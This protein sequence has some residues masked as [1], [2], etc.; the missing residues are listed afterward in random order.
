[1]DF[2]DKVCIVTGAGGGIGSAIANEFYKAGA[3]IAIVDIKGLDETVAKYG[4]DPER[5]LC[6]NESITEEENAKAIM[7]AT[8]ERFGKIDNLVNTAGICGK[9]QLLEDFDVD[10]FKK[11]YDV[12]VLGTFLMM[13]SVIPYFKENG[14]GNIVNFASISGMTGYKYETAYGG[15]KWAIIGMTKVA[16]KELGR[17]NIRVNAVSP[18]IADTDMLTYTLDSYRKDF[19]AVNPEATLSAGP[20]PYAARPEQVA[21][22]VLFACS[23]DADYVTGANLVVDGGKL[24]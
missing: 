7:A 20:I 11:I 24:M 1:M 12:N 22:V 10:N 13:K 14:G 17:D 2:T 15:S 23:D 4:F 9:Y 16:A 6:L 18:G 3:K 21:K 8:K 19:G 5:V